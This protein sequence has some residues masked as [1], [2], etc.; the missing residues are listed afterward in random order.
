MIAISA[1]HTLFSN[2]KYHKTILHKRNKLLKNTIH[3]AAP[4]ARHPPATPAKAGTA[5]AGHRQTQ[6][7][8]WKKTTATK[9]KPRT[10]Q[11][12]CCK[13]AKKIQHPQ[14]TGLPCNISLLLSRGF[15]LRA[16]KSVGAA[17]KS[18]ICKSL[19]PRRLLLRTVGGNF[20]QEEIL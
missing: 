4:I 10:T 11:A 9:E 15:Q 12:P 17:A 7:N 6:A 16:S 18:V 20:L 2:K 3:P 8:G 14:Q 19:L 13:N 1:C 5:Q